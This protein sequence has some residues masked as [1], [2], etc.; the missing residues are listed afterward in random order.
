MT[1]PGNTHFERVPVR[2]IHRYRSVAARS[3]ATSMASANSLSE[4]DHMLSVLMPGGD[5]AVKVDTQ[6]LKVI[7]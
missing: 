2:P 7:S 5:A 6:T 3:A 4:N 1:R